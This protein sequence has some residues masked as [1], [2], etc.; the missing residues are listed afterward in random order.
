SAASDDLYRGGLDLVTATPGLAG[1]QRNRAGG[2][3]RQ[4][5]GVRHTGV[6]LE[7]DDGRGR[8]RE[9]QQRAEA[10]AGRQRRGEAAGTVAQA[11]R[12]AAGALAE[13]HVPHAAL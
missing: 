8:R 12:D 11:G 10:V 13:E 5:E 7:R 4:V 1:L 9:E 3:V 6:R 2:Q